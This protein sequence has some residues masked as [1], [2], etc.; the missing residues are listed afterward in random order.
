MRFVTSIA[1]SELRALA[2]DFASI[3][4]TIIP[5]ST[6]FPLSPHH[7]NCVSESE[8][9]EKIDASAEVEV[10][11]D[12]A[13]KGKRGRGGWGVVLIQA[14]MQATRSG[15][16]RETTN[17]R[18]ELTAAIEALNFLPPGTKVHLTTDSQYVQKGIELWISNWKAN[19]WITTAGT[20]VKNMEYWQRLDDLRNSRTVRWSWVRGHGSNQY[21]N[22]ADRLARIA[23][24]PP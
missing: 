12:G 22:L 16:E 19:G 14:T 9:L 24:P 6:L 13:C 23:V 10:F 3:N 5:R 11:T 7:M 21:N 4:F 18:M 20:P 17:N 1:V 15:G 8:F 2:E